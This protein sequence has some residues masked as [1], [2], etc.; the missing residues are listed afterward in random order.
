MI[1][2][3]GGDGEVLNEVGDARPLLTAVRL[4]SV[5]VPVRCIPLRWVGRLDLAA[6]GTFCTQPA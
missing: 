3:V 5:E 1:A 2:P 4:L 6:F